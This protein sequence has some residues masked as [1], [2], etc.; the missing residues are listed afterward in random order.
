MP[1]ANGGRR[2]TLTFQQFRQRD[3]LR[4]QPVVV[5]RKH[6]TADTDA[7][8]MASGHQRGSSRRTDGRNIEAAE[9]RSLSRHAINIRRRNVFGPKARQIAIAKIVRK[10]HDDIGL[11]FVSSHRLQGKSRDGR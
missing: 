8:R 7:S 9:L 11:P 3:L 2:I 6:D 4:V 10:D 1:L 5:P